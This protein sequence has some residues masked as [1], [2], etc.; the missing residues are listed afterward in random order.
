MGANP[1]KTST[2]GTG[3]IA[4]IPA[5]RPPGPRGTMITA[6]PLKRRYDQ[7]K[8]EPF[9]AAAAALDLPL[10]LHRDP[11]AWQDPQGRSRDVARR[12]QPCDQRVLSGAVDVRPDLLRCLRASSPPQG[13]HRGVRAGV[14]APHLLSTMDYTYRE[15]HGEP[16]CRFKGL[17]LRRRGKAC[18]RAISSAATSS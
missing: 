4:P 3:S 1:V 13:V 18:S 17:P 6:Y 10:S 12:Q 8:Y 16:I 15:R 7:A 2:I 5:R 9:W 11:A 14:G